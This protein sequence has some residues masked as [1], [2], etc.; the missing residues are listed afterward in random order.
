M[1][2]RIRTTA[3]PLYPGSFFPEEGSPVT[4]PDASPETA[5]RA[6][7]GDEGWFA[8]E[9]DTFTEERWT[10]GR[11]G[12]QWIAVSPRKSYR[13]Y[14]GEEL[15]AADIP[16]IPEN[17]ILLRNM[18]GNGWRSVVRTR[19]GNFQPLADGDVVVSL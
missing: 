9:V 19:S 1:T 7:S 3:T 11:G 2:T 17:R 6:V 8:V 5:L 15:I 16:D 14:A 12:E 13:I 10:N 4:I 18:E